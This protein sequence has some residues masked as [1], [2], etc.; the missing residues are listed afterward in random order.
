M[1]A[2]WRLGKDSCTRSN[3]C[4]RICGHT[5]PFITMAT[6]QIPS[7]ILLVAT[8][9]LLPTSVG[10]AEKPARQSPPSLVVT[11]PASMAFSGSQGGPFSP[12]LFQYRVSAS[13][14][15][16]SYSI[17]TPSWLTVSST[18][19]VTDTSG[20]MITF[21]INAMA[22]RLPPGTYRSGVAFTN[23]TNGQGSATR[24]TTL[25]IQAPSPPASPSAGHVPE[26]HGG[27]L[28][29]NHGGYLLDGGAS[30]LLAK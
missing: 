23:V 3:P 30:R 13:S 22:F 14:G 18:F 21:T 2:S 10:A 20:V 26:S 24:P 12:S 15:T 5:R 6:R 9:M 8:A 16:V 17:R 27:Y 19:G 1:V 11:P 25:V 28:L 29:D 4:T 7:I